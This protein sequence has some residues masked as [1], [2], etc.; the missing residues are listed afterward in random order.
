VGHGL[1]GDV[2]A[3]S[4]TWAA[5]LGG[6]VPGGVALAGAEL[7]RAELAG[8]APPG[9]VL[10]GSVLAGSVP[11]GAS[12]CGPGVEG[13]AGPASIGGFPRGRPSPRRRLSPRV[14]RWRE[15]EPPSPASGPSGSGGMVD[16]AG[17]GGPDW[18][19]DG[20]SVTGDAGAGDAT[21]AVWCPWN[22]GGASGPPRSVAALNPGLVPTSGAAAGR[23]R[24][25]SSTAGGW[26]PIC[27][28]GCSLN[29]EICRSN[30]E[31]WNGGSDSRGSPTLSSVMPV[32]EPVRGAWPSRAASIRCLSGGS[33]SPPGSA[34]V[35]PW[36]APWCRAARRPR[37]LGN[38]PLGCRSAG[39][40]AS[41]CG[42]GVTS[43]L[44]RPTGASPPDRRDAATAGQL[45][46]SQGSRDASCSTGAGAQAT[47]D[48]GGALSQ[49]RVPPGTG[50]VP[51]GAGPVL[52][53]AGP[54][55][56]GAGPAVRSPRGLPRP[57][58]GAIPAAGAPR[59]G[60]PKG[61]RISLLI[62]S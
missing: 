38:C 14:A 54:V 7:A 22:A 30:A 20:C 47:G 61:Q 2:A 15:R 39:S 35:S 56:P 21:P 24:A 34:A 10:A 48:S 59:R 60:N 52:P 33:S 8:Y 40:S 32:S 3:G 31:A 18:G 1:R 25:W 58:A 42:R 36:S 50:P 55:P 4:A 41:S 45:P 6:V 28:G 62:Q 43:P 44:T 17:P 27:H 12:D 13:S 23:R 19:G 26:L 57:A 37:S 5:V 46:G 51:P 49:A 29:R 11:A 16:A 9:P 53:V